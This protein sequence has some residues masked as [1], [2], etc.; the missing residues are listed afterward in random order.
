MLPDAE[1]EEDTRCCRSGT[2]EPSTEPPTEQRLSIEPPPAAT[3]EGGGRGPF[4]IRL[5]AGGNGYDIMLIGRVLLRGGKARVV[6]PIPSQ[7][8]PKPT[9]SRRRAIVDDEDDED[10]EEAA[11]ADTSGTSTTAQIAMVRPSSPRSP[12]LLR[13]R[14]RRRRR[15]HRLVRR[16]RGQ[17]T[18]STSAQSA[19]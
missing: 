10:E 19:R 12:P 18:R 5:P 17:T 7:A 2:P 1:A 14:R 16:P 9:P 3:E 11:G 4:F 15:T 8:R 6:E 13:T